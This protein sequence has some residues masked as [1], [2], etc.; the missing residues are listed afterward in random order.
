MCDTNHKPNHLFIT[1]TKG[2]LLIDSSLD[3]DDNYHEWPLLIDS[4]LDADD[5]Y[6]EGPL[7][8]DSSLDT[9]DNYHEGPLLIEFSLDTDDRYHE[10]PLLIGPSLDTDDRY[11]DGPHLGFLKLISPKAKT[12]KN[13]GLLNQSISPNGLQSPEQ[14]RIACTSHW[15]LSWYWWL[16]YMS[17]MRDHFS[18][19]PLLMLIWSVLSW[20][21]MTTLHWL[22]S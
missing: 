8:I 17:M 13:S 16:L 9:D 6:H 15:P 2:L 21:C 22:F 20:L 3:T 14:F 4:S 1:K 7:L 5:N 19:T 18:L 10:W 11:H 12:S